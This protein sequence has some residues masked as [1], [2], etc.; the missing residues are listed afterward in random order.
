MGGSNFHAPRKLAKQR[1]DLIFDSYS[2]ENTLDQS[3]RSPAHEEEAWAVEALTGGFALLELRQQKEA[4]RQVGWR[5]NAERGKQ[6]AERQAR[7]NNH[8]ILYL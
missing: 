4:W 2:G 1:R 7:E 3:T 5:R 6:N 8:I